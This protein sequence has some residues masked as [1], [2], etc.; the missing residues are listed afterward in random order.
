[1]CHTFDVPH[2]CLSLFLS[3]SHP[4]SLLLSRYVYGGQGAKGNKEQLTGNPPPVFRLHWPT[5]RWDRPLVTG[6]VTAGAAPYAHGV[7][8]VGHHLVIFGGQA[9]KNQYSNT[10]SV[11]NTATM[12]VSALICEAS[13]NC[14]NSLKQGHCR[15]LALLV[16][17]SL[18][19]VWLQ[20]GRRNSL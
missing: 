2:L 9:K 17:Y 18:G 10:F 6:S 19:T 3:I 14:R 15:V 5:K 7:C 12:Y 11:L 1:M 13:S 16:R 8:A 20:A 4:V